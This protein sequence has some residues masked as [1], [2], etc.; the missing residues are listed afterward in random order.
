LLVVDQSEDDS[1]AT[2]LSDMLDDKRLR[3]VHIDRVGLSLAY[4]HGIS[5]AEAPLM[6]FTD[7]DCSAPTYWLKSIELQFEKHPDIDLLY[8]QTLAAPELSDAPGVLPSLPIVREEMLSRRHGFRIYGM[9]ANFALTKRLV[10]RIGSFDEALGGGGPLRSSQDFDLQFRAYRSGAVC[11]L[12]PNVWVHHYG[13]RDAVSW[14]ATQI[15]YGVG[16]GAF[17]FKHVRCGDPLAMWLLG[18]RIM[19]LTLRQLVNPVRRR[20]SEWPYLR[21]Y[22]T[23]IARSLRYPVNRKMRLFET[24]VKANS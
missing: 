2:A 19:R 4:N 14:P 16:D 21:S 11:L 9:G 20:P 18:K 17:Y 7:D 5:L 1:T 6:A 23:G 8:G 10:E 24:V 12:S 3:Y 15:A 22:F 13:I